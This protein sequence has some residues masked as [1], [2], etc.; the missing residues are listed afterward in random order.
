MKRILSLCTAFLLLAAGCSTGSQKPDDL[1][2]VPDRGTSSEETADAPVTAPQEEITLTMALCGS[3]VPEIVEKFNS[4]DNGYRI[5][6]KDYSEYIDP[7]SIDEYGALTD[8]NALEP[9]AM[10]LQMDILQGG[11]VDIVPDAAFSENLGRYEILLKKG[12]FIDLY[13]FMENDPEVNTDTLDA[14]ILK[15]HETDGELRC[16]PEAY[17]VTTLCGDPEYVGTKQNWTF[18]D[19]QE[20]WNNA[21]DGLTF[22]SANATKNYVYYTVMR[23]ALGAFIDYEN[24]TCSFDSPLF[25]QMLTFCNSFPDTPE[26]KTDAEYVDDFVYPR[27][28]RSYGSVHNEDGTPPTLVGYPSEDG[29]GAY[30][31][32]AYC[33]YSICRS[34]SPEAQQGAWQF[35]RM[36]AEEEYQYENFSTEYAFPILSAVGERSAEE[37]IAKHENGT[38]NP[39]TAQSA[40]RDA[41]WLSREEYDAWKS[42]VAGISKLETNINR[43]L[44]TIV[45]EEIW[46]MFDGIQ[47]AEQTANAIQGRAS[48]MISEQS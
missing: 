34:A 9:A 45:E 48:I 8:V 25:V 23:E 6:V 14:H 29:C 4:M 5:E 20:H 7:D 32:T 3:W 18:E 2:S 11:I 10:Q 35:L 21:P 19:M 44:N 40:E 16:L 39:Y 13:P 15:L 38:P 28:F 46:R 43:S 41:G 22:N 27:S 26:Y 1:S 47:T 42:Y 36:L 33:R 12:A 31:D 24:A 17:T 30:I 37:M